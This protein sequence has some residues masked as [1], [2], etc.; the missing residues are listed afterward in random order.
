MEIACGSIEIVTSGQLVALT[1]T[2][3]V[4]YDNPAACV[5]QQRKNLPPSNPALR[6]PRQQQH[7]IASSRRHVVKAGAVDLRDMMFD[8]DRH[9]S[10]SGR[11]CHSERAANRGSRR[12]LRIMVISRSPRNLRAVIPASPRRHRLA[13]RGSPRKHVFRVRPSCTL[14]RYCRVSPSSR[15]RCA[16]RPRPDFGRRPVRCRESRC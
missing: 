12:V 7:R 4:E 10:R 3:R 16:P 11:R 8:L 13:E 1:E 2:S 5:D 15:D 6:P 14:P 9:S